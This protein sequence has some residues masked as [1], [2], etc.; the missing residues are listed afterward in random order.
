MD[1]Q[2]KFLYLR[3]VYTTKIFSELMVKILL[4]L[5][6]SYKF[7]LIGTSYLEFF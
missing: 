1:T 3:F 5:C 6:K 7:I 2:I 4:T